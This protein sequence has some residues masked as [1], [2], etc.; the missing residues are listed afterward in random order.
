MGVTRESHDS[1][2][3]VWPKFRRPTLLR[4][5]SDHPVNQLSRTDSTDVTSSLLKDPRS[6]STG[7]SVRL[8]IIWQ[9]KIIV[10][11]QTM[12]VRKA[13]SFILTP[14]IARSGPCTLSPRP[15]SYS[16]SIPPFLNTFRHILPPGF[17]LGHSPKTP[18]N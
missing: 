14:D 15:V 12:S 2:L 8:F 13:T 10:S 11:Q 7:H 5:H 17:T 6:S 3:T 9:H 16:V 18:T 4:P 1:P